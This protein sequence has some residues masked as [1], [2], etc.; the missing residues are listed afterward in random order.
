MDRP[1]EIIERIAEHA[2]AAGL[3]G[4]PHR[5]S[6]DEIR[7]GSAG[8]L[9]IDLK[10]GTWFSHEENVGGGVAD[11]ARRFFPNKSVADVLEE[12]GAPKTVA[13]TEPL[14][15]LTP[16]QMSRVVAEYDYCDELGAVSYTV[17]RLE[18]KSFRQKR[19]IDGNEVWSIK[20]VTPLPFHLPQLLAAPEGKPVFVVEGEKD[21]LA[22]EAIGIVATCNSGGAGK[23]TEDHAKWLAGRNIVVIAD[24]DEP[25]RNHA[26]KVAATLLPIAAAVKMIDLAGVVPEKG[27][28]SDALQ[29][30]A[31]ELVR[32]IKD[33]PKLEQSALPGR[34]TP[35]KFTELGAVKPRQWIY[36]R[37]LIA[38]YVSATISPGGVGKTT[39]EL[40]EAIA[41]ATGK[42]ILGKAVT[43]RRKV[44]HYNLEDPRE[45]LLRRVWALCEHHAIDPSELDGWL[46]LDSA[47]D[48]KMV[49]AE[50]KEDGSIGASEDVADIID[51]M[52]RRGVAV[53]QIDPFVRCHEANENDNKEVDAVLD[54]LAQIAKE[55]GAAIDIVHHTRK[56]PA[57][58]TAAAGDI[59]Q[60]RGAGAIAGAVR[61]ARTVTPMSDSDAQAFDI[62]AERRGWYFR[63]D[64]A[65]GNMSPP[66]SAAEWYQRRSVE[67]RNG[68]DEMTGG[69]NV[70]VI[71]P[72]T[73]P[74]AFDGLDSHKIGAILTRIAEG[75]EDGT[76]KYG[77]RRQGKSTARWA[78]NAIM[79]V[80][81][82]V[83]QS[84]AAEILRTWLKNDVLREEEYYA[85]ATRKTERGLSVNWAKAPG[86]R[87]D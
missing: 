43:Q 49:V 25:G 55:T 50:R 38:G 85:E 82:A 41:L 76:R 5:V 68:I 19:I 22:L 71:E 61:S 58:F 13:E 32:L 72:W 69:D 54:V 2:V 14:R 45:E 1:G 67:L 80:A 81:P 53:L 21:V 16:V 83:S 8:S 20:G 42:P 3:L 18:P 60:A 77:S 65:K 36:S 86:A 47:R 74:D 40:A 33:T 51:D 78:G 34:A 62:P 57:G 75:L 4:K 10:K 52:K 66:A 23:W 87:H 24:N 27:D 35:F 46:F 12:F 17:V 7:F 9:S 56:S 11:L 26:R 15:P 59:N 37:H 6:A 84:S 79:E 64:D 73:P 30:G 31:D 39:L 48:R 29:G 44:W 70:G 28:V 63:V